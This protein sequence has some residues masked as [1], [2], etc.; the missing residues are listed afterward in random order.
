MTKIAILMAAYNASH[1]IGDALASLLRQRDAAS[2][3]IIVV[4]DGSTDAT[5][6]I[7]SELAR[8]APELRLIETP[9]RGIA[10]ARNTAL[11][12]VAPDTD[13]LTWLDSDDLSPLGRLRQDLAEFAAE[14]TLDFVYGR[15]RLFRN[16]R[17]D[18]L[19]PAGPFIDLRG[20]QLGASLARAPLIR[21]IG[22]F[23]EE[24][25]LAEDTDFLLRLLELEPR[26][27]LLDDIRLYYRRHG[28]NVTNDHQALKQGLA[29]V[30]GFR[31][32]RA[33]T[34]GRLVPIPENFFSD[35]QRVAG[36]TP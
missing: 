15:T 6:R 11:A 23:N 14:P 22:P 19:D 7:V 21:R 24:L 8:Q 31:L 12:A 3:D 17:D 27:K 2:L 4:N 30:L 36:D 34:T 29:R 16:I 26:I 5:G 35:L 33:R 28:G 32:K 20:V 13:F 9:N 10:G 18:P 1:H 25:K